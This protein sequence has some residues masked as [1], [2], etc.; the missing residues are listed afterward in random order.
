LAT[1]GIT[2]LLCDQNHVGAESA[3]AELVAMGGTVLPLTVDIAKEESVADL[4]RRIDQRFGR[5]DV[6]VNNAGVVPR[7]AGKIPTIADTPLDVWNLTIGVNLTVTFLVCSAAILLLKRSP[8]GRVI[9]IA[10]L[11]GQAYSDQSCY[12]AASKAGLL[13]FVRILAGE[14]G[15]HGITVNSIAPGMIDTPGIRAVPIHEQLFASYAKTT[16][17]GRVGQVDEVAAAVAFLAS[18]EAAFITGEILN[19]NGG[20]FMP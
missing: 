12:Y 20:A 18:P 13:G 9:N 15:P 16:I 3:A 7:V 19:L 1:D 4:F 2:V 6:L 17:M 8:S 11:V 14:L 10:S 5:I